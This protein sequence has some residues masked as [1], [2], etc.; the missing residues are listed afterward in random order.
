MP[1]VFF[2]W[3]QVLPQYDTRFGLNMIP[4]VDL[5]WQRLLEF[6]KIEFKLF[7]NLK[8]QCN[9][10]NWIRNQIRIQFFLNL[11]KQ[12]IL[13]MVQIHIFCIQRISTSP[14]R[15]TSVFLLRGDRGIS[16]IHVFQK[17]RKK[18]N[19]SLKPKNLFPDFLVEATLNFWIQILLFRDQEYQ[20]IS[21]NDQEELKY[22]HF[23]YV[24]V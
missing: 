6:K 16:E 12:G 1:N 8:K 14:G 11:K 23:W 18:E 9:S 24:F 2:I 20:M 7:F 13:K 22:F 15:L 4:H 5:M 3:H 21:K 19:W 17:K 10:K